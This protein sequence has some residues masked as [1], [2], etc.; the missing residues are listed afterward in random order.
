MTEQEEMDFMLKRIE[1]FRDAVKAHNLTNIP[2]IIIAFDDKAQIAICGA[3][4]H[5]ADPLIRMSAIL[6]IL[7]KTVID[8]QAQKNQ[9]IDSNLLLS[10]FKGRVPVA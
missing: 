4:A 7:R 3:T 1:Q 8:L 5:F 9:E 6:D 10:L 2:H